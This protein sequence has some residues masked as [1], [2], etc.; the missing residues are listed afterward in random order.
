MSALPDPFR[1]TVLHVDGDEA[2]RQAVARVL[3]RAGYRVLS[4]AD[5]AG[6]LRAL[7]ERPDLVILDV[8][9]PD[10]TGFELCRH[11]RG[12]PGTAAL[13]IA[14]LSSS[15]FADEDQRY[16]ASLGAD[17]FLTRPVQATLLVEMVERL[18]AT[19]STQGR[20]VPSAAG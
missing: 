2:E 17:V 6:A 20:P 12:T 18:T 1:R 16:A 5:G 9:L 15:F 10:T 4:A 19:R 14:F 8:R 7:E 3:S 11:I 13:P